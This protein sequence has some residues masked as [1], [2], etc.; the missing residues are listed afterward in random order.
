MLGASYFRVLGQGQVYGLS[1]RGLAIDIDRIQYFKTG[2]TKVFHRVFI[3]LHIAKI[4]IIRAIF[5]FAPAYVKLN[6]ARIIL[7]L[8]M[9]NTIKTR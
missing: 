6:I 5:N 4:K 1:A 3:V 9:C 2:E 7:I 8:A